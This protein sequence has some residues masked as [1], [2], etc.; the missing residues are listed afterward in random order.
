MTVVSKKCRPR[1]LRGF[2][3]TV[4]VSAAARARDDMGRV[5]RGISIAD[6]SQD[7][8]TNPATATD[9]FCTHALVG[10][11]SFQNYDACQFLLRFVLQSL[12]AINLTQLKVQTG[13]VRHRSHSLF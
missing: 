7:G 2:V 4:P 11:R 1:P 8:E 13:I 5:I 10:M 6:F 12:F 3:T 9:L